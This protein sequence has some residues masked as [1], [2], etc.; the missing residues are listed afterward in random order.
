MAN[1]VPLKSI[2]VVREG[3]RVSPPLNK[4]FPFNA[5]E[6]KVLKEGVDYR[7]S[8]NEDEQADLASIIPERNSP[9]IGGAKTNGQ[10]AGKTTAMANGADGAPRTEDRLAGN[11][12]DT[13]LVIDAIT[14][15]ADLASLREAEAAGANRSGVIGAIDARVTALTSDDDL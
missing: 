3:K 7:K 13:K 8:I 9:H 6:V 14:D 4:A 11:V 12:A 5:D 2:I 1:L 10:G 15:K